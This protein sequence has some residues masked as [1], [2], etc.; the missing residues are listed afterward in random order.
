[1]AGLIRRLGNSDWVKSGMAYLDDSGERC[2]F[3]QQRIDAD[4]TARL[5]EY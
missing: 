1:M 3:C 2:P 4:L 5:N